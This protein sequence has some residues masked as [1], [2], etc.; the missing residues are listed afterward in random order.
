MKKD[1]AISLT[2]Q[3]SFVCWGLCNL[4]F[5]T[6][7]LAPHNTTLGIGG[8]HENLACNYLGFTVTRSLIRLKDAAQKVQ[9]L[10]AIK[11]VASLHPCLT[12]AKW[13]K[14]HT[15]STVP[16]QNMLEFE[17]SCIFQE[18]MGR[19]NDAYVVLWVNCLWKKFLLFKHRTR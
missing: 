14:P 12:N 16:V 4:H 8:F 13:R 19:A 2:S 6:L 3:S 1:L 9:F 5:H 18:F 17:C 11:K 7:V 10:G 15:E